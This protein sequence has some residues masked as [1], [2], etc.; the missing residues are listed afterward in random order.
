[1]TIQI[2]LVIVFLSDDFNGSDNWDLSG[3]ISVEEK[4]GDG[5]HNHKYFSPITKI[6]GFDEDDGY[7][8]SN[9]HFQGTNEND[10]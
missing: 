7:F 1:M 9:K 4:G 6:K 8:P 2:I 10:E 5:F 3:S